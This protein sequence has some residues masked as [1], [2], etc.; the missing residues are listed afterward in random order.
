MKKYILTTL[1]L[2]PVL[3]MAFFPIMSTATD[4]RGSIF[5]K[6][7]SISRGTFN[8]DGSAEGTLLYTIGQATN[9]IIGALGVLTA[10]FI[11]YA[12]FLWLTAGG[13]DDQIKKAKTTIRRVIIGVIIVSLAYAI[14]AFILGQISR[15]PREISSIYSLQSNS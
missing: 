6:T 10:I 3:L 5:D 12:G 15:T 1:L 11:I 7:D 14:I 9:I 8:V 2:L 13:N 4:L